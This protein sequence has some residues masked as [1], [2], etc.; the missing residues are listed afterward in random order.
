VDSSVACWNA[1]RHWMAHLSV[2]AGAEDGNDKKSGWFTNRN[3]VLRTGKL[4]IDII[5]YYC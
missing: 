1:D 2:S 5:K 4:A 3:T